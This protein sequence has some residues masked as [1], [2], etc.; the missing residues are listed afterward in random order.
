MTKSPPEILQLGKKGLSILGK[1]LLLIYPLFFLSKQ[2][3]F[4]GRIEHR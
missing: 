2:Q 3:Q 4:H 1:A